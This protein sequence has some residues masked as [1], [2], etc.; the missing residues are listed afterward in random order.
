VI[1]VTIIT[2]EMLVSSLYVMGFDKVD[3][4]LFTTVLGRLTSSFGEEAKFTFSEVPLSNRFLKVT[5]V[6]NADVYALKNGYTIDTPILNESGEPIPLRDYLFTNIDLM[7][8]LNELDFERI[9]L[10]KAQMVRAQSISELNRD[11]FSEK[12]IEILKKLKFGKQQK[13]KSLFDKTPKQKKP[14]KKKQSK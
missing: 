9:I 13:V 8:A 6:N 2:T 3:T 11:T 1:S 14:R 5:Q 10:K 4:I 12:E 7:E